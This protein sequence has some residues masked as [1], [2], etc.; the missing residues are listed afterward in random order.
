[1]WAIYS[2]FALGKRHDALCI[3]DDGTL[4]ELDCS[5]LCYLFPGS[6]LITK[7]EADDVASVHLTSFPHILSLRKDNKL[8]MKLI[9]VRLFATTSRVVLLD[10][11]AFTFGDM[12][13]LENLCVGNSN[14]FMA[15]CQFAFSLTKEGFAKLNALTSYIPINSG[16]GYIHKDSIN[17][18]AIESILEV[19]PEIRTQDYWTEQTLYALLS[20]DYGIKLL[21]PEFRVARGAGLD[22]IRLKHYVSMTRGFA[23]VEGI[24][25]LNTLIRSCMS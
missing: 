12:G 3:H 15:D 24:P 4:S 21:G 23:Y 6:R 20:S 22:G 10:S 1:M 25:R 16:F 2:W 7:R 13:D 14:A 11:D 18:P 5:T 9:D 8:A 19:A 17:L